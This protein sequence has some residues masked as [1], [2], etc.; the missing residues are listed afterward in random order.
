MATA[1][2][3]DSSTAK[4]KRPRM[5]TDMEIIQIAID[6]YE[7]GL[8][9]IDELDFQEWLMNKLRKDGYNSSKK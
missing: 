4:P 7:L 3:K 9:G 1:Q 8:L 6:A 5:K 2:L